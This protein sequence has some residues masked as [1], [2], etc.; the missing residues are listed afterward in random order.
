MQ[1]EG[2]FSD[3]PGSWQA[4]LGATALDTIAMR[5]SDRL[6]T[7]VSYPPRGLRFR[8]FELCAPNSCR[9]VIVGQDPYHG[10]G[11]N[12]YLL[13]SSQSPA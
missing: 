7:D 12:H 4:F 3:L 8:A 1:L 6:I 11:H 9:V 2:I 13:L 10:L 5:C